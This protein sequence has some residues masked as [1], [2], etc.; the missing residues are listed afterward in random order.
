MP[1][2]AAIGALLLSLV[3]LAAN[4]GDAFP[5]RSGRL[6]AAHDGRLFTVNPDS[7]RAQPLRAIGDSAS[8]SPDGEQ[9]AFVTGLPSAVGKVYV[10]RRD[11]TN[12]RRV[13]TGA[14]DAAWSPDGSMLAVVTLEWSIKL[15][16]TNG[17]LVDGLA[18]G[19]L[20]RSVS[21][22]PDGS[23]LAFGTRQRTRPGAL[24]VV[25]IDQGE[26]IAIVR[27]PEGTNVYWP[28]WSP[29]GR[30]ITF[31]E[32]DGCRGETCGGTE[33]ISVVNADGAH[34]RRLTEGFGSAWSPD[35]SRIAFGDGAGISI[36]RLR[37][38][39]RSSVEVDRIDSTID[40]QPLCTKRGG[41]GDDRLRGGSGA[42]LLCGLGGN[43]TL[44]GG[45]GNDRLFGEGGDDTFFAQDHRF[46]VLGCGPGRDVVL[47][48]RRDLVGRD[49]ERVVR[50]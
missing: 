22:S 21:W 11:G 50:G 23:R 45:L 14:Y 28:K 3:L 32:I 38:G 2:R 25:R 15:L 18:P 49:C 16:T 10:A 19:V 40:W 47:A 12:R 42:D 33:Y 13:F 5:G 41:P 44:T 17:R 36:L 46:D 1:R 30:R 8:F 20:V 7:S 29:D 26:E 39:S 24:F 31:T 34:K 4:T 6:L 43:D 35:G 37:D 48:D 9:I 27:E